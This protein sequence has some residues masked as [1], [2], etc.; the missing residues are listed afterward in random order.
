MLGVWISDTGC[1]VSPEN[2]MK[3]FNLFE[4]KSHAFS[5]KG[6]GV[7]L[8]LSQHIVN[9]MGGKI[10]VES[11]YRPTP[12][13]DPISGTCSYFTIPI[14]TCSEPSGKSGSASGRRIVVTKTPS[15]Q[16]NFSLG[17]LPAELA[18]LVV[19]DEPMNRMIMQAKLMQ[20]QENV[21]VTCTVAETA[22]EALEL[23][24]ASTFDVI[25]MDQHL[26]KTGG[27][28]TGA[29]ATRQLRDQ[30]CSTPIIMCSG[31]CAANDLALYRAAGATRVWP[32]PYPST[33]DMASDIGELLGSAY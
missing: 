33:E 5:Q 16:D 9:L 23:V 25:L 21:A 24:A 8:V 4:S 11:P 19:E 14:A 6:S 18:I 29:Q 31:N 15:G 30:G 22:E 28:L 2:A 10:R 32:K 20:L 12:E 27:I 26:E 3:L 13:S 17:A 7:G 1:G